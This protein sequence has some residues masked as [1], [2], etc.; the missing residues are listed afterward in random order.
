M[1]L[2]CQ[3]DW[4]PE[5]YALHTEWVGHGQSEV[6]H[7]M[8]ARDNTVLNSGPNNHSFMQGWHKARRIELE[9]RMQTMRG[10]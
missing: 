5:Y 10:E 8:R 1:C 3:P 4:T 6:F 2:V 7:Q 9:A